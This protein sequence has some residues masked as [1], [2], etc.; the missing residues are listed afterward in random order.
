VLGITSGLRV[1]EL[2][3]LT[4]D[5]LDLG[6]DDELKGKVS[7]IRANRY[8][9]DTKTEESKRALQL[10]D[11]AIRALR[12]HR[13]RQHKEFKLLGKQVTGTTR[14][15][16]K[17]DTSPYTE[18]SARYAFRRVLEAAGIAN[19]DAWTTRE[20]RTTFVSIMSDA[21]VVDV[22][23]ADM[24]GHDVK[25]LHKYYRKQL[26]PRLRQSANVIN[27]VFGLAA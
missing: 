11:I 14:V 26:K 4:W 25:T 10:A 3:A 19:P 18:S 7:V 9:G 21:G 27:S 15:F 1:D 23:I 2:D 17:P 13:E 24:C 22:D 5:D 6:D 16:T 8:S 20:T 12:V